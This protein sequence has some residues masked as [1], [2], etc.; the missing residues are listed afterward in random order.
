[1][2][3]LSPKPYDGHALVCRGKD[4]EKR[5]GGELAKSLRRELRKRGSPCRVTRTH[6]LGQCKRGCV[7]AFEGPKARWWGE[8]SSDDAAE[9][10]KKIDKRLRTAAGKREKTA[11]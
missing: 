3:K 10:A 4:C 9:I 5:G 11:A 1:M 7:V 6:C 2:K 8:A